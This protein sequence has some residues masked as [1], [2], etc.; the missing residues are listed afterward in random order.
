[1]QQYSDNAQTGRS[2]DLQRPEQIYQRSSQLIPSVILNKHVAFCVLKASYIIRSM[3]VDASLLARREKI[4]EREE[5]L[6][7][8][9]REEKLPT[10][11]T[12]S[13]LCCCLSTRSCSFTKTR[14][15]LCRGR[16]QRSDSH[17][18]Y[19]MDVQMH[20]SF[21]PTPI[22]YIHSSGNALFLL[23]S[24]A[25]P[26]CSRARVRW[27]RIRHFLNTKSLLAFTRLTP[28]LSLA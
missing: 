23:F 27:I 17:F 21:M 16:S 13:P 8:R 26:G 18:L 20:T 12:S 11:K 19:H 10:K 7:R 28:S 24:L 9:S 15:C 14:F 1:M 5:P 3:R 4:I 2:V 6:K 25:S 22:V